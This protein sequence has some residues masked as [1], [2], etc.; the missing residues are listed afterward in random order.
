MAGSTSR[1]AVPTEQSDLVLSIRLSNGLMRV[2]GT[3]PDEQATRLT[4]LALIQL[5]REE[6]VSNGVA[7]DALGIS[8]WEFI[9]LLGQHGVPY[10]DLTPDELERDL[11]AS[12][13]ASD[14]VRAGRP[15]RTASA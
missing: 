3:A 2:L 15:S 9:H 7:A 10:L 5:W 11:Q 4:E 13:L 6:A 14:R 8:R 12:R 1:R